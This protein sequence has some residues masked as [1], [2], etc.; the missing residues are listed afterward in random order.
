MFISDLVFFYLLAVFIVLAVAMCVI[1][2]SY[3]NTLQKFKKFQK[4]EQWINQDAQKKA[5]QILEHTHHKALK[6]IADASF[7]RD[8]YRDQFD[9]EL[10]K[11]STNHFEAFKKISKDFADIYQKE[12]NDLKQNS[13][14]KIK[15]ITKD[16][17]HSAILE[18]NDF[19]NILKQE[20]FASQKIIEGKIEEDYKLAKQSVEEYKKQAMKKV[21]DNIY[22]ILYRVSELSLGKLISP[23]E[24]EEI[25][26]EALEKA[27]G[28]DTLTV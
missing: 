3:A 19:K 17:E 18:I 5:K 26:I 11:F 15:N 4:E 28:E 10:Q 6:I 1:V 21:E 25:V 7:L 16:I 9:R 8:S 20:T 14:K 23:K 12:I 2:V 24:H 13:I 22:K 27:K